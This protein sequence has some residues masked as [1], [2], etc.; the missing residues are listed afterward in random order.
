ME[1]NPA[2]ITLNFKGP[3]KFTDG[4]N[5]LFK[6][7]D[8]KSEG[9]YIWT[10][11]KEKKDSYYVHYIGETSYFA[12]R[13]REHLVRILGLDYRI[14]DPTDAKNGKERIVWEGLWRDKSDDAVIKLW[15]KYGEVTHYVKEYIEIINI[16]F[17]ETTCNKNL[18]RHIEGSIGWNLGKHSKE[19]C[20]F[21][22]DDNHIA[23]QKIKNLQIQINGAEK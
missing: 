10:I 14:I 12:K 7:D 9:V 18:R 22:P 21:Y 16:F 5:Y 1:E 20:I 17:A 23:V 11:K 3:Y 13:Q 15:E 8:A 6:S 4:D 2:T 19:L